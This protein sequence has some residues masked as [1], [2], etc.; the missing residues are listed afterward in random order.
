MHELTTTQYLL[1]MAIQHAHKEHAT[2][3][4]TIHVVIGQFSDM[5]DKSI[6]YY[7]DILSAGTIAEGATIEFKHIPASLRCADCNIVYELSNSFDFACPSC[8]HA[9][10]IISGDEFLLESIDINTDA[11]V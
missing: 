4:T 3:I 1:K 6:Q 11:S 9:G 5:V 8:G 2:S 7:W 10:T